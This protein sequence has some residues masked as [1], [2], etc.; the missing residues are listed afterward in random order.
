MAWMVMPSPPGTE[1]AGQL[2]RRT[3]RCRARRPTHRWRCPPA[4]PLTDAR[5]V[6]TWLRTAR[7]AYPKVAR[8]LPRHAQRVQDHRAVRHVA[9]PGRVRESVELPE[10]QVG[11]G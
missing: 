8:Q 4:Q 9:Q 7:C 3:V 11:Q 6:G 2:S 10:H 1:E 5:A